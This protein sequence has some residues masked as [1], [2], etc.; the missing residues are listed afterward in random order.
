ME[1][2]LFVK[3]ACSVVGFTNLEVN[4]QVVVR[5]LVEADLFQKS[6]DQS[7]AHSSS[8]SCLGDDHVFNLPFC[9]EQGTGDKEALYLPIELPDQQHAARR[10]G[11]KS[12]VVVGLLP[13]SCGGGG[14]LDF[15]NA[16]DIGSEGGAYLNRRL[17]TTF[18]GPESRHRCGE[19]SWP[20]GWRHRRRL[21]RPI[22]SS[23]YARWH[24]RGDL[25]SRVQ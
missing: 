6:A 5:Q 23:R 20:R 13:M 8:A 4:D 22:S 15:E 2:G 24:R 7:H 25:E 3:L 10:C 16:I 1:A 21:L 14:A 17:R 12:A 19:C 9:N 11:R 18:H